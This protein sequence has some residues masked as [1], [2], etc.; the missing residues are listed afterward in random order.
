MTVFSLSISFKIIA[1]L[2]TPVGKRKYPATFI[3][4][5]EKNPKPQNRTCKTYVWSL[6][7]ENGMHYN[8]LSIEN[9]LQLTK[10]GGGELMS[11]IIECTMGENFFLVLLNQL[12]I[13]DDQLYVIVFDGETKDR[14]H[15]AAFKFSSKKNML[16]IYDNNFSTP[17]DCEIN[18]PNIYINFLKENKITKNSKIHP[19]IIIPSKSISPKV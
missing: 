10:G 18:N 14:N 1:N 4:S 15:I 5:S 9:W 2:G 7:Q 6:I 17:L 13:I 11:F 3:S 12:Q 16:R 19:H 8:E